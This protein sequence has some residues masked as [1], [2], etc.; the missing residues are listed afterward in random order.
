MVPPRVAAVRVD[1]E[2]MFDT[3]APSYNCSDAVRRMSGRIEEIARWH[4]SC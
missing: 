1:S 4:R 3:M 2:R